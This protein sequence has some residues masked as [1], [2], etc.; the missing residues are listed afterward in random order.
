MNSLVRIFKSLCAVAF[1]AACS[2]YLTPVESTPKPTEF[3]YNRWLLQRTYLFEDE[4]D[5]LPETG[6]SA[7][8]LYRALKDPYTR[9]VEPT[10]SE[11]AQTAIN[12]SMVPG[13][14]GMTYIINENAEYPIFIYRV[15]PNGPA[16]RAGVPRYANIRTVNGIELSGPTAYATYMGVLDTSVTINIT[17]G[18]DSGEL[19]FSLTKETVYAPTIFVDTLYGTIFITITGFKKNTADIKNGTY[20]ELRSYLDS[21]QN[22]KE[23]RVLDLRG[24]PGGHVDQ[25]VPMADLF[26]ATGTLSSRTW[27]AFDPDGKPIYMNKKVDAQKGDPG[28]NGK[29][30]ILADN[31]SASCAEIFAAAVTENVD[32]PLAG[33]TTYG[34]GVG[35]GISP[36]YLKGAALITVGISYDLN[37]KT[38]HLRGIAPDVPVSDTDSQLDSALA[39]AK[40][41]KRVRTAGYG[42]EIRP[43]FYEALEKNAG[44]GIAKTIPKS[45][46]LGRYKVLKKLPR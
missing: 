31:H 32:I 4:L 24:N 8:Q 39:I 43:W 10:K 7:Q 42:S 41:G 35:Y 26:V 20:G 28:E 22:I 34:K 30:I 44:R 46:D 21:T 25:C 6:D 1:F 27:R 33:T 36:T 37:K 18:L 19:K 11:A 12:T 38:Y 16:G 5:N 17:L 14:V 23:P 2:D 9:Y 45:K 40:E 29:F 3:E 13:D 15:Y